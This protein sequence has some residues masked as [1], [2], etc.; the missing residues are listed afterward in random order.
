MKRAWRRRNYF[1]KEDLQGKYIFTFFIFVVAGSY[2]FTVIFG[3]LSSESL[4]I[5]Y[6]DYHLQLG[7]TPL[8][9]IKEILRAHWIFIAT[10]GVLV[11]LTS[12]FLSHRVA[13]PLYRFE[14]SVEEMKKG[15]FNFEIRLRSKDEAKEL[16]RMLNEF[17]TGLSSR[18]RESR[19][20]TDAIG[21]HLTDARGAAGDNAAE[22]IDGALSLNSRLREILHSFTLKNDR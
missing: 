21:R 14:R 3:L 9:L 15:N 8:V 2:L 16:A 20:L 12:M 10:G 6:E 11:T 22:T 19:E 7:K 5:V 13:G 17:N 4:T 1:I 18:L